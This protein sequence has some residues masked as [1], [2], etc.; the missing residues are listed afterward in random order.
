MDLAWQLETLTAAMKRLLID[1]GY[2]ADDGAFQ[3][4]ITREDT[5]EARKTGSLTVELDA[6][7]NLVCK[8]VNYNVS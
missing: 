3:K 6:Y 1:G 7:G 5:E 2:T 8:L 4:I